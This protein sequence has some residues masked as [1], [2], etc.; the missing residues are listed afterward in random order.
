MY[1]QCKVSIQFMINQFLTVLYRTRHAQRWTEFAFATGNQHC[2]RKHDNLGTN[3][4][5]E[6]KQKTKRHTKKGRPFNTV[7][8]VPK[9]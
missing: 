3:L 9:L 4:K 7:H 8:V 5:D 6:K 2:E 1:R